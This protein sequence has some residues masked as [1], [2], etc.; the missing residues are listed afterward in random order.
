MSTSCVSSE[1]IRLETGGLLL[2]QQ[3]PGPTLGRPRTIRIPPSG[4]QGPVVTGQ[5]SSFPRV[6]PT[7]QHFIGNKSFQQPQASCSDQ[8]SVFQTL[9][10]LY[11]LFQGK[12]Q[13]QKPQCRHDHVN[14]TQTAYAILKLKI[15]TNVLIRHRLNYKTNSIQMNIS[16][17]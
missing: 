15:K 3:H 10:K 11:R 9:L 1:K 6:L 16:L 4:A 8:S 17:T 14:N 13:S 12:K 7:L 2:W 5:H